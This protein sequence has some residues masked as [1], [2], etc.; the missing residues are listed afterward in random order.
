M[1]EAAKKANQK[2]IADNIMSFM[3]LGTSPEIDDDKDLSESMNPCSECEEGTISKDL[4]NLYKGVDP[5]FELKVPAYVCSKCSRVSYSKYDYKKILE[6]QEVAS[7]RPYIKV[8]I[9]EG[10]ILKYTLH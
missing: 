2:I 4:D 6:A 1:N 3:K 7:G 5:D 9:Q 8:A 10:S